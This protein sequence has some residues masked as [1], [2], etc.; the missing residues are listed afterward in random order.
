MPAEN[1]KNLRKIEDQ[2]I[3]KK[4]GSVKMKSNVSLIISVIA[5]VLAVAALLGFFLMNNYKTSA[6][7]IT[8]TINASVQQKT[9]LANINQP[10]NSS[11]LAIIN[12]AP[13]SYFELAGEMYLNGSITNQMTGQAKNVTEIMWNNK[14]TVIYLGST[15]CVYCAENSWAIALAL[16]RFGKF[17]SLYK[18]YSALQDSDVPTLYW[19]KAHLNISTVDMGANYTSSYINFIAIEDTAPITGGFYL[20]PISTI[21][22]EINSS[23]NKEYAN[24]F[25]SIVKRN[26]FQ[27][28][29]YTVWGKF[30]VP[31]VDAVDFGN[32]T[33]TSA[34]NLP[35]DQMS[36]AQI[37]NSFAKPTSQFAITEYA[38]ADLYIAMTC[39]SINN[40]AN[41]CS[42]PAI[43]KI[44]SLNKY[45]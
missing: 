4:I 13:D 40:T 16:S 44:E 32:T 12:N 45:E 1:E 9:T 43:Q 20:Q 7:S 6:T 26:D 38:A 18:G 14:T 23:G 34:S 29:P 36:H 37:L 35:I 28:T 21:Q 42:L 3:E 2:E 5:I 11:E 31:G 25:E 41:I 8:T 33:P 15:T 24:A 19:I 39:G 30:E 17:G 27:G 10:L 22:N